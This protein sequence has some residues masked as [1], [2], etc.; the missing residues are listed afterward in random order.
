VAWIGVL[1]RDGL[2]GAYRAADLYVWPAVKEA[3]GM[4]F[5]EAQAAGLPVVAGRSGGVPGVVADGET[6]LLTPE[7]DIDA[8]AAAVRVMIENPARR[9]AMGEAA[10]RRVAEHHD[11][12][13]AAAFLDGHI[14]SV[15]GP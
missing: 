4:S 13:A 2:I 10:M 6:G 15:L 12:P 7:G 9:I 11:L 5:L 14:R 3:W 8:F 1:D